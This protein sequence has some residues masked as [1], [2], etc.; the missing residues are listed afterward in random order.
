LLGGSLIGALATA[1][2][3]TAC[4]SDRGLAIEIDVG[5]TGATSVELYLGKTACASENASG[6]DCKTITP[7]DSATALRGAVWF[8]DGDARYVSAVTGHTATFQLK[9]DAETELPIV[10]AVGSITGP[11]GPRAVATA[12]LRD[13]AIPTR[14]AQI[15]TATL[16]AARP[17]VPSPVDTSGVTE[18]RVQVWTRQTSPSACVAVEHWTAGAVARDFVVPAEDPDCDGVVN[19]CNPSAYLGNEPGGTSPVASCFADSMANGCVLGSLPCSDDGAP[20]AGSCGPLRAQVCLP[21]QFC[22]C[23]FGPGPYPY[24]PCLHDQLVGPLSPT[25]SSVPRVVCMVPARLVDNRLSSCSG[26]DRAMIHL[27]DHV[28][29]STCEQP[30]LVSLA[31]LDP[32]D[33]ATKAS[34]GG[35]MM[36]LSS[37]S[38][39]CSFELSWKAG[40]HPL[41]DPRGSV[42]DDAVIALAGG[43]GTALL[44]L[45]L[46]FSLDCAT[47]FTCTVDNQSSNTLWNC[48]P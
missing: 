11:P 45:V 4:F 32:S 6:I 22:D 24:A 7:P 40:T 39:R 17:V 29:D 20:A 1:L 46:H 34:F 18:D 47:D 26:N 41:P 14:S 30:R 16:V 3:A 9:A 37:P 28:V 10:I 27:D 25:L 5:S 42:D 19:E 21:S 43:R 36:E 48:L 44:P 38:E 12:T 8:R 13:L 35:A 31:S 23:R 15:V 2:G 33:A